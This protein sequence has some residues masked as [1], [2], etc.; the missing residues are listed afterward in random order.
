MNITSLNPEFVFCGLYE[1]KCAPV[2]LH[3]SWS[4]SR[5]AWGQLCYTFIQAWTA[6][7][8]I[9]CQIW[10]LKT[11]EI[12]IP[13]SL[14]FKIFSRGAFPGTQVANPRGRRADGP[15]LPLPPLP[16]FFFPGKTKFTSKI[17]VLNEYEICLKMMG[18]AIL[19]TQIFKNFL[20]G[21]PQT[22]LESMHLRCSF[23]SPILFLTHPWTR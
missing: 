17:L 11:Q 13:G 1:N 18:M 23:C 8:L 19:E 22:P 15:V 6:H 20:G 7:A 10:S 2:S 3:N 12:A 14:I 21:M 16:P 5:F 9:W 4:W